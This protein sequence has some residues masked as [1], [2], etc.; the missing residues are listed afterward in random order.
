MLIKTSDHSVVGEL[1]RKGALTEEQARIS[2]NSN[3][4]T[5]VLGLNDNVEIDIDTLSYE[6]KDRFYVCTDGVW[7]TM[8]EPQLI[9]QFYRYPN[10]TN[11]IES[12]TMLIDE[13]GRGAGG[14]HDNHTLI[15]IE[16]K[17][18]SKLKQAMSTKHK[19]LIFGMT[20]LLVLSLFVNL[21]T[22]FNREN[23]VAQ[24]ASLTTKDSIINK[25][26]AYNIILS[27]QVEQL[28]ED[29]VL[30]VNQIES[31][32]KELQQVKNINREISN[33]KSEKNIVKPISQE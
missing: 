10:M 18:S 16:T 19:R 24:M 17:I 7:G 22:I 13:I 3:V 29:S 23:S 20:I 4:I 11:V 14:H 2:P 33:K 32:E 6:K 1:V 8:P 28:K 15:I 27:K 9:K 12:T 5:R 30:L 21:I 31:R 26:N 25:L